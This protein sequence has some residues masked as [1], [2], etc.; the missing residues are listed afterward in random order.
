MEDTEQQRPPNIPSTTPS[1]TE[2]PTSP[3]SPPMAVGGDPFEEDAMD[4][5][6]KSLDQI[7]NEATRF[8]NGPPQTQVDIGDPLDSPK[9]PQAPLPPSA[10]DKELDDLTKDIDDASLDDD[11]SPESIRSFKGLKTRY[12][13][14]LDEFRQQYKSALSEKDSLLNEVEELREAAKKLDS[15]EQDAVRLSTVEKE[16]T[17]TKEELEKLSHYRKKYDFDSDPVVKK[18]YIDPMNELKQNALDIIRNNE[19]DED[20]WQELLDSNSEYTLNSLIDSSHIEG[21]NAQS[22]KDY[23]TKYRKV[24]ENYTLASSPEHIDAAITQMRGKLLRHTDEAANEVFESFKS[25]FAEHIKEVRESDIN[26]EHNI[27][28]YDKVIEGAKTTYDSFR[29]LLGPQ[30]QSD[31]A[32]SL[33]AQASL[34]KA[35]YPFQSKYVSHVMDAYNKLLK[36]VADNR[37]TPAVKQSREPTTT[38]TDFLSDIN[39]IKAGADKSLDDI[40]RD[41][42]A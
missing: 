15:F 32:L 39:E 12:K 17:E 33:L 36:E 21:M 9:P 7:I 8:P 34:M 11:K 37:G 27:L 24:K 20:F 23:V 29:K 13:N 16:L 41:V 6:G 35:A 31:Q 18:N 1:D 22:L 3:K 42:K 2:T 19:I 5:A 25:S 14:K 38:N 10:M 30:Y 4:I 26:R 28:V 40:L